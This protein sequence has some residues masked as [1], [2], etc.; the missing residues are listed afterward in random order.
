MSGPSDKFL[1]QSTLTPLIYKTL[2]YSAKKRKSIG[3]DKL[4]V[5]NLDVIGALTYSI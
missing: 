3:S 2:N 4:S 1:D 5:Y